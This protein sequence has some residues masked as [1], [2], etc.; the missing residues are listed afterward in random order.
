MA[1]GGPI[2]P[3]RSRNV[4]RR[5]RNY[6]RRRPRRPRGP[7]NAYNRLAQRA[8][9][10]AGS[11]ADRMLSGFPSRIT[12][13]LISGRGAYKVT[14]NALLNDG[15]TMGSKVPSFIGSDKA[16]R[17]THREYLG[18]VNS[19]TAFTNQY[20]LDINPGL[21][22]TFPW[23]STLAVN[24]EQYQIMGMVFYFKST[25]ATALNSTN[26]ALGTVIMAT[27]YD[28]L[29]TD[30]VS[31]LEME[32]YEYSSSCKPAEDMLH[33]IECAPRQTTLEHLYVRTGAVPSSAD[34]R[35]YDLGKFTI[36]TAGSQAAAVIGELWVSYTIDLYKP[37][38]LGGQFGGGILSSHYNIPVAGVTSGTAYFGSTLPDPTDYEPGSNIPL[39]F[40]NTTITFPSSVRAGMYLLFMCYEGDSTTLTTGLSMAVSGG[41]EGE[42]VFQESAETHQQNPSGAVST[43][44]WHI[45]AFQ[46][47]TALNAN[48]VITL[49]GGTMPT[50]LVNCDLWVTQYNSSIV[51]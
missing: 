12:N 35:M 15:N 28:A 36:A 43:I 39:T 31:K 25:S 16:V 48:I 34:Q 51:S 42:A 3:R 46:V 30:F 19:S 10:I 33:P 13:A 49:S 50:N 1:R 4:G 26:T 38:L 47:L 17:V 6:G 45:H 22:A 24:F 41:G 8:G 27:Q 14:T 7:R 32:N 40:S 2:R 18:D 9:L 23:L 11:V 37:L 44:A 21:F 29:D 5:R 20:V